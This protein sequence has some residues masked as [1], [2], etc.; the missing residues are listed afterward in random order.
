MVNIK[1]L[2]KDIAMSRKHCPGGDGCCC[3]YSLHGCDCGCRDSCPVF[4]RLIASGK[5]KENG[6]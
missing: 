6:N 1:E 2:E 3:C 4:R 5:S